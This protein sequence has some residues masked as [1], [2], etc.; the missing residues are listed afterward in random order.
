MDKQVFVKLYDA[1]CKHGILILDYFDE[2]FN[3]C[4]GE[5]FNECHELLQSAYNQLDNENDRWRFKETCQMFV[6]CK[7]LSQVS[8]FDSNMRLRDSNAVLDIFFS[9]LIKREKR[10]GGLRYSRFNLMLL[11]ILSPSAKKLQKKLEKI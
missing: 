4:Y 10:L 9:F 3:E 5:E 2:E 8:L 7:D 11:K 6:D 1:V